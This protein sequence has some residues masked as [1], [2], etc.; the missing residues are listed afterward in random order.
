MSTTHAAVGAKFGRGQPAKGSRMESITLSRKVSPMFTVIAEGI[1]YRTAIARL[2]VNHHTQLSELWLSPVRYSTSTDRHEGYF[3][4]GFI[5]A[6]CKN[7]GCDRA[8]ADAQVF[9]TRAA[10]TDVSRS[11]TPFAQ[12]VLTDVHNT[13]SDVDLPRLRSATRMGTLMSCLSRTR[14][15]IRRLTYG[16]PADYPD[17][18]TLYELQDMETFIANT[19]ALFRH[20]TPGTIDEVRVAVRAWLALN[21]PKNQ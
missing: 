11:Y 17:A 10:Q 5:D 14:E 12:A 6:Y 15:T 16:L 4:D 9:Y 7:H 2:V 21:N 1:S 13:L 19:M 18:A 8:T 3:R 20:D